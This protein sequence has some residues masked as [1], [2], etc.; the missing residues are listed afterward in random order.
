MGPRFAFLSSQKLTVFSSLSST[1]NSSNLSSSTNRNGTL[2]VL[3]PDWCAAW[4]AAASAEEAISAHV[5]ETFFLLAFAF[6]FALARA[7]FDLRGGPGRAAYRAK[8]AAEAVVV[9]R[10]DRRRRGHR[11]ER[12]PIM[13]MLAVVTLLI[14]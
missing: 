4:C 3:G 5:T 13:V 7:L 8:R 6:P 12:T 2:G 11:I 10:P 14:C 1:R 9:A